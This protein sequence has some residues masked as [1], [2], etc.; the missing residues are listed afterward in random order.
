LSRFTA[1]LAATAFGCAIV[2]LPATALAA[3]PTVT[4][5]GTPILSAGLLECPSTPDTLHLD[6]AT[7][8]AVTFINHLGRTATLHVGSA[9]RQVADKASTR[10][11]FNVAAEGLTAYMVPSCALDKGTHTRM[12]IDVNAAAQTVQAAGNNA[13][14]PT[15]AA[16]VSGGQQIT[17]NDGGAHVNVAG[18]QIPSTAPS[19]YT[20]AA[21]VVITN[22]RD[23]IEMIVLFAALLAAA[24]I[25]CAWFLWRHDRRSRGKDDTPPSLAVVHPILP[26]TS[27][28]PNQAAQ[29]FQ[30]G[31]KV[32]RRE[33]GGNTSARS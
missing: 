23:L 4:F 5:S 17:L 31:R 22:N 19:T 9:S 18:G 7:G 33:G 1:T 11:T 2:A 26:D 21:P 8:T 29:I 28:P 32:G 20:A 10:F 27:V 3:T 15:Q 14:E 16:Q 24:M 30:L 6:I 12:T 25:T 13:P